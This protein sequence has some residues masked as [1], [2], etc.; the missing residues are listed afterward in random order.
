MDQPST[1]TRRQRI[2]QR[3]VLSQGGSQQHR[4][5]QGRI[6]GQKLRPGQHTIRHNPGHL[7]QPRSDLQ[8]HASRHWPI[9]P[10]RQPMV[11]KWRNDKRQ[12]HISRRL[13]RPS[14]RQRRQS[15]SR[16]DRQPRQ[17]IPQPTTRQGSQDTGRRNGLGLDTPR[18]STYQLPHFLFPP[19][20][21]FSQHESPVR[22]IRLQ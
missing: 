8:F 6:H 22:P 12:I 20:S 3:P 17:R 18:D 11:H 1:R 19:T 15:T 2:N 5:R 4:N 21:H 13:Q 16:M 14:N 9:Q 7:D 10:Q